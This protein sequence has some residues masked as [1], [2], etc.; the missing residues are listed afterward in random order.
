MNE[1][2]TVVKQIYS[3]IAA[4]LHLAVV[5]LILLGMLL[6]VR[7]ILLFFGSLSMVPGYKEL[8]KLSDLF[9]G[10]A[11]NIKAIE[12]PYKGVFD[13]AATIVLI[14]VLVAE[15]GLSSLQHFFKRQARLAAKAA[16]VT[17]KPSD[18]SESGLKSE[19]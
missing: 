8:L 7:I 9:L 17:L 15:F 12:T 2:K 10:P 1:E 5:F 19:N 3:G 13:L 16:A 11:T 18:G 6:L 4:L 14:I